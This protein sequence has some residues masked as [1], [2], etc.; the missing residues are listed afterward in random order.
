MDRL[1]ESSARD[2]GPFHRSREGHA[3]VFA[4]LTGVMAAGLL[5][6]PWLGKALIAL[7]GRKAGHGQ[8]FGFPVFLLGL[9]DLLGA[10][11]GWSY[12]ALW[13]RLSARIA[14]GGAEGEF[15]D[16]IRFEIAS[17]V[18]GLVVLLLISLVFF[19]TSP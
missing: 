17:L 11:S 5:I 4:W 15:L 18:Q 7:H 12:W 2:P 6:G 9:V 3:R 16:R 19:G 14:E 13:K 8:G 10:M 1:S